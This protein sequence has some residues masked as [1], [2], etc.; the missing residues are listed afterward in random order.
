M[1]MAQGKKKRVAVVSCRGGS[2]RQQQPPPGMDCRGAVD[3][4]EQG[5]LACQ[6]GCLGLGS[7]V[8]ACKVGAVSVGESG[9]AEIDRGKCVGC[10]LCVKACP[11]QLIRLAEREFTINTRCSSRDDGAATRKVCETGCIAC[12]VCEKNCPAGA[13]SMVDNHAVIDEG[14]CI[15]CGMCATKC[16]RHTITDADGIFTDAARAT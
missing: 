5:F 14:L 7:C 2:T 6:W 12:R 3:A 1:A 10:G 11:R 4:G 16:P 15:V 8:A 13:I 9:A